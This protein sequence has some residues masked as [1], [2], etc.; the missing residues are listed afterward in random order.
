ML[1]VIIIGIV[2]ICVAIMNEK[3]SEGFRKRI[4]PVGIVIA[5]GGLIVC[6]I[7]SAY[8]IPDGIQ[9]VPFVS[10]GKQDLGPTGFTDGTSFY[11]T[12]ESYKT[13]LIPGAQ[14]NY[15]ESEPPKG[16]CSN[17]LIICDS[18]FCVNC[19]KAVC[20]MCP[21]C[22]EK[23]KTDYCGNCGT[24]MG[25]EYTSLIRNRPD[26]TEI[27]DAVLTQCPECGEPCWKLPHNERAEE[28]GAIALCTMCILQK[29]SEK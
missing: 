4:L 22:G 1:T 17:C 28:Q 7:I 21:N 12:K 5:F 10:S 6:P 8:N 16:Y 18:M 23:C 3:L 13:L 19:G 29:R 2:I 14:R 26:P 24:Y 20:P 9:R 25:V 15:V 11:S 27:E